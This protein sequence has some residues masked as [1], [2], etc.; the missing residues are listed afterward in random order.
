M[1]KILRISV[2]TLLLLCCNTF[3]SAADVT[4]NFKDLS[5]TTTSEGF[6]LTEQGYTL[7][8]TKEKGSNAPIQNNKYKDVRLYAKNTLTVAG[9]A[10]K[11]IVFNISKQ[12]LRRWCDVTPSVGEMTA[13]VAAKTLTWTNSTAVK[14]V[15]FTVGDDVTLGTDPGKA[16]QF[17]FDAMVISTESG[18][19]T[20]T[21]DPNPDPEIKTAADIAAFKALPAKTVAKLTLKDAQVLYKWTSNKGNTQIFIRDH[22]GALMLFNAGLDLETN[23]ILN[24]EVVLLYDIYNNTPEGTKADDTNVDKL[25]ITKGQAATPKSITIDQAKDYMS[26]LVQIEGAEIKSE[27]SGTYTNYY[28][29]VGDQ[30]IQLY[31]GFHLDAYND[32]STLEGAKNKT[33]KG[34]VSMFKGNYQITIISIDTTTGIDNLNAENKTINDNAPMYNLAGQRVDK[35][36]KGVVIQN[37]K[38]FIKR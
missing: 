25:T 8:A 34:I 15:T 12:G 26:D 3:I 24:G 14:E 21:P 7:T 6:T 5:V 18:E 28:A 27:Q 29:H 19:V 16:G 32:L 31:N 10:F 20:P 23:D 11:Q 35:T 9:N 2:F 36:Y 30:K 1:N 4:L 37:G 17:D 13:D 33:V 22:S 38:K